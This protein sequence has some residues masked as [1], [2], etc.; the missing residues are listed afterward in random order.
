LAFWLLRGLVALLDSR[1]RA[2]LFGREVG[3]LGAPDLRAGGAHAAV[4]LRF[5][6]L[7]VRNRCERAVAACATRSYGRRRSA[8]SER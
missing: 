3:T 7:K 8:W 5:W 4:L 2:S 1:R 6:L